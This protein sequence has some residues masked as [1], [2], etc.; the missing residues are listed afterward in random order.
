VVGELGSDDDHI[1]WFLLLWSCSSLSSSGSLFAGLGDS[2][3]SPPL[4]F[5]GCFRSPNKP[6]TLALADL[7]WGFPT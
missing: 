6:V 7:L 4:L 3:W 5:L 2:V 1:D